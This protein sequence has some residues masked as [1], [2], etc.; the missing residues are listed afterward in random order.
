MKVFKCP[1]ANMQGTVYFYTMNLDEEALKVQYIS[2]RYS[3]KQLEIVQNFISETDCNMEI[4]TIDRI[5]IWDKEE[6]QILR[7]DFHSTVVKVENFKTRRNRRLSTYY[8]FVGAYMRKEGTV[9][10]YEYMFPIV[11]FENILLP[12]AQVEEILKEYKKVK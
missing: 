9:P 10:K 4:A 11:E 2:N 12:T 5:Y 7:Y 6:Q 1:T 3:G 8:K